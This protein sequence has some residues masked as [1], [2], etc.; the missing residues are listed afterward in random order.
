M[1]DAVEQ[2]DPLADQSGVAELHAM[3]ERY[4]LLLESTTTVLFTAAV[5]GSLRRS[6]SW[7][8]FTGQ[9][10]SE[11]TGPDFGG[12]DVVHPDDRPELE[13]RW[14]DAVS[15]RGE[16]VATY[17]LRDATGAYRR[18]R[19]TAVPV[20][21]P[22][23]TVREWV[24]VIN[25]IEDDLGAREEL[26]RQGDLTTTITENATSALF[27]MDASGR[28]TY[29]NSAA[30]EMFGYTLDEISCAP[31]HDAIHHTRPDGTP[32]PLAECPID[33]AL[34]QARW[35][36]PYEDLFVRK[37]GSFVRVRAAASPILRSG[38]PIG[39]VV[40]VQ[41]V[42]VEHGLQAAVEESSRRAKFLAE[43]SGAL[44]E[45]V[46]VRDRAERAVA[47][48]ADRLGVRASIH[49]DA[50]HGIEWC[51]ATTPPPPVSDHDVAAYAGSLDERSS[52]M[53][54]RSA[55]GDADVR[56]LSIVARGHDLGVLTVAIDSPT[57]GGL[58]LD[59]FLEQ[60]ASRVGLALDN[61]QLFEWERK[62]S[63]TL[64]FGLLR[65]LTTRIDEVRLSYT[66][67][68]GSDSMEVGGDWYDV[69]RLT[70]GSIA[71]VV[72]DVV[73][74]G[75]DAATEMSLLRGAV[76][77]FAIDAAPTEVL[78][79]LDRLMSASQSGSM[80]SL[81]Y[82]LLD[83][84]TSTV[85]YACAG[86]PPPLLLTASGETRLLWDGRSTPLGSASETHRVET[87]ITLEPGDTFVLYTDGLIE[88]RGETIDVGFRRLEEAAALSGPFDEGF[89]RRLTEGLRTVSSHDDDAC[90][91][92][93]RIE[94]PGGFVYE[95]RAA[96]AELAPLRRQLVD[97]LA[98]IGV[99]DD[100]SR[101]VVL[102]TSEAAANAVEHAYAMDGKGVTV[103]RAAAEGDEVHV[104][105]RDH[106]TWQ[107]PELPGDRGRGRF[108]MRTVM[109]DVRIE[110]D[111][112]G[113]IVRMRRRFARETRA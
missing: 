97:W 103:V 106:G 85:R 17:R 75:L 55:D 95:L 87:E 9:S 24:G 52:G 105:V 26:A 78:R 112:T 68:P 21:E 23:G 29:M 77:A 10:A 45:R 65:G 76:R 25:D 47:L 72:G 57:P 53:A 42:T 62:V 12:F 91:L 69:F 80:T 104:V 3:I 14:M 22:D 84:S 63:H 67:E 64:Q 44:D 109:D 99:G 39:T 48:L 33:R 35:V 6:E 81:A 32:Y 111:A 49:L 86:H 13:R 37:D 31:L 83:P 15:A 100:T 20:L 51:A 74:H 50:A 61:A 54:V 70:D 58:E 4:R 94:A 59:S 60:I 1:V 93:A 73:G 8:R 82:A 28:P 102:A 19:S 66:Y 11:Y 107:E 30:V 5:D 43:L 38:T 36:E 110:H 89:A 56:F 92:A 2:V 40:E 108:L 27:L 113:T 101:E 46:T 41:D 16:L 88:R 90:V 96:P 71:L 79:R 34:P 7:E 18:V 98:S